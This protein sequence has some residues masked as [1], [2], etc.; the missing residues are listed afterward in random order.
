[1]RFAGHANLHCLH[2]SLWPPSIVSKYS[3]TSKEEVLEAMTIDETL[4]FQALSGDE[5]SEKEAEDRSREPKSAT[6]GV[7]GGHDSR[8]RVSCCF[9]VTRAARER[10][11]RLM[12]ARNGTLWRMTAANA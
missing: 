4:V 9:D 6:K 11:E 12:R 10:R 5:S 3:E 8:I 2:L 1:M 7:D